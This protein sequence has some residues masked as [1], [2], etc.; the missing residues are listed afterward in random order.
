MKRNKRNKILIFIAALVG[1]LLIYLLVFYSPGKRF[2][3][4]EDY[5]LDKDRPYGTWLISELLQHYSPKRKFK[6]LNESLDYSLEKA[7]TP[8]NYVFIGEEIY[9][10]KIYSD[11]LLAYVAK[12][13]NAFIFTDGLPWLLQESILGINNQDESEYIDDSSDSS[14]FI[15]SE[16][17]DDYKNYYFDTLFTEIIVEQLN[18]LNPYRFIYSNRFGVDNKY[19]HFV[20][21]QNLN[22][23][24]SEIIGDFYGIN[25]ERDT[26]GGV[27]YY[28]VDYGKGSL[29][30]HTQPLQFTNIQLLDTNAVDYANAV[31]SYL[32]KGPVYWEEHNWIF[33]RPTSKTW[34]YKPFYRNNAESPLTLILNT[35]TLKWGWYLLLFFILLFVI[36]EGKRKQAI[37]PVLADKQ[38]TT[39]AHIKSLT[40]LYYQND[41]HYPIANKMFENFLWYV[42]SEL[43][44]DTSKPLDKLTVEIAAKSGCDEKTIESIFEL[45]NKIAGWKSVKSQVFLEFYKDIDKFYNK[46]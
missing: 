10:E 39:L 7:E 9:L 44:I 35:P 6:V 25:S 27:N 30:F 24:Q 43:R 34:T 38:N 8:S 19:W 4:S 13:N 28:R 23:L 17:L 2:N 29:Y 22:L 5:K 31:F 16:N 3:W 21:E 33:N 46:E 18:P 11:S 12:G 14:V 40:K 1:M 37:I 36:F 45:W 41:E 42:R 20:D 15:E 32:N 26:L